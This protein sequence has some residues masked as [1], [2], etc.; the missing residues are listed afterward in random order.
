MA[1]FVGILN[2]SAWP[3]FF[4]MSLLCARIKG[5][6]LYGQP[7]VIGPQVHRTTKNLASGLL[8]LWLWQLDAL[9]TLLDPIQLVFL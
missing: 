1:H 6:G 5:G 7:Q 3:E 9:I 4:S 2:W 8:R